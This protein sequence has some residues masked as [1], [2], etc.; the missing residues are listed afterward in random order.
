MS[1]ML[2][3]MQIHF[4]LFQKHFSNIISGIVNIFGKKEDEENITYQRRGVW[5]WI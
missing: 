5:S 3:K 2:I 1:D 4:F